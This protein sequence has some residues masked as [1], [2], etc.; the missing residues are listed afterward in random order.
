MARLVGVTYA[1]LTVGRSQTD[2]SYT[3]SGRY[4]F[5]ETYEEATVTFQVEV[6]NTTRATFLASE[7]ALVA[8]YTKPEQALAVVLEATTR[9]SFSHSANTGFNAR[10]R[11][12]KTH[13]TGNSARYRCEV[14]VE[15]PADL[16]GRAGRQESSVEVETS[17]S[18][19]DSVVIE[20]TWTAVGANDA[21]AQYL[22]NI[23]A[24]T[25][26]VLSSLGGTWN[27]VRSRAI[28]DTDD[29]V[30]KFNLEYIELI[31]DE[32]VGTLDVTALKNQDL[33]I[34]RAIRGINDSTTSL[35][36]PTPLTE[37]HVVY[38]T[39]V[40]KDVTTDLEGLWSSTVRP[41]IVNQAGIHAGGGTTVITSERP[42]FDGPR[43]R[44]GATMT[45]LVSKGG[46][47]VRVRE[48]TTDVIE[49]GLL[50]RA[51]W[52]GDPFERDM[53]QGPKSHVRTVVW[54]YTY[55]GTED[56]STIGGS[57]PKDKATGGAAGGLVTA[58][59]DFH[60]VRQTIGPARQF[61]QG[62]SSGTQLDLRS[63]TKRFIYVRAKVSSFTIPVLRGG[64]GASGS[65]RQPPRSGSG[66]AAG[67]GKGGGGGGAG[68][69]T[70]M[71]MGGG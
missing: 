9:H 31:F 2:S 69:N 43:N 44:I 11:I 67:G 55:T 50:F 6:S 58:W 7:A 36:A 14:T 64:G 13:G 8:A 16:T 10:P 71:R 18:G 12:T 4:G 54:T 21:R 59:D 22:A 53:Y 17:A 39:D 3:L 56:P 63:V 34:T 45:L 29:K 5:S 35:G 70:G 68:D 1:G 48:T 46:N 19:Q 20:G 37:V 26:S 33:S 32:G 49:Q 25:S 66:N 24:Y 62:L 52:S 38:S 42:T 47:F 57:T 65:I 51:V 15:L 41:H 23:N 27:Q 30:L 28:N 40:D 60:L 61:K